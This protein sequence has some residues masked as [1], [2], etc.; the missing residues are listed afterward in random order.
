MKNFKNILVIGCAL[1]LSLTS[2]SDFLDVNKAE[3]TP[4]NMSASIKNRL[5]WIQNFYTY[6]AGIANYRTA[7]IAGVYY[8]TN[9]TVGPCTS[10]WNFSIDLTTT[11]YQSFFISTGSNLNELYEAAEKE[12]A[13]HYMAMADIYHALG[14]MEMLDLYGEIPYTQAIDPT[15]V[16]PAYDNGKAIFN[17]VMAKLDEAIELLGKT[18]PVTAATLKAGDMVNGGNIDKWIKFCYGLKARYLLKLSKKS[19]LYNP[20]EILSC[21]SKSVTSIDDNILLKCYNSA[22]DVT[23]YLMGDPVM[24][25]GNWN[26]A[27]YGTTQRISKYYY[28]LLTN[29]RNAGVEDP[30][31][32][33]IVPA[34]MSNI[35][36]G[37]DGTVVSCK[38]MRSQPVDA[39]GECVRLQAG[40]ASSI[41][42]P[43]WADKDVT[44]T[45]TI[46]DEEKKAAFVENMQKVHSVTVDGDKVK[47]V[48]PRGSVYVNSSNYV[49]AG[50]TVYVSLRSNSMLTGNSSRSEKDLYW[51]FQST[52]AMNANAVG[53]TG[54][55]QIRPVSDFELFTY[56]EAC[57][58]KAEVLFRKGDKPGAWA[59]YKEGIKAHIDYMQKKLNSWKGEGYDNPDMMPMDEAQITAYMASDAVCQ[60][61][62]ELTM[63]DIMLQ[64]YVAMG[65]SIENWNDMRRFNYST[66]NI[67]DFG[68]VYPGFDRSVMFTGGS[69]LT[70]TSKEEPRYWPRRWR[71]PKT[72]EITYNEK[73]VLAANAHALDTDIWSYPVWWDCETDAEY[74]GYLK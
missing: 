61:A 74:E 38:W 31:F 35:K 46:K 73:N 41:V 67:K 50:D 28:D 29:M 24:T 27:A 57:F 71:L 20:D 68:V 40:G 37:N 4:S 17:G 12:G 53:S 65:C 21:L 5:P 51:Y 60:N 18:Q 15:V 7:C 25:N 9:G 1:T 56:H 48:Y 19:D 36:I 23:D 6:S 45:Y 55:F 14:F 39:H 49:Y 72:L 54:S 22:D 32:T 52:A 42:A 3:D 47:V 10:T 8:S 44:L 33:K 64:K 13:Y 69:K 30:R 58:I 16:N 59:A 66:G 62:D 70:G 26:Y 11:P 34:S 63:Q 2:C 43:T